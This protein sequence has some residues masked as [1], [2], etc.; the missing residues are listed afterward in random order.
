MRHRGISSALRFGTLSV[1]AQSA[2]KKVSVSIEVRDFRQTIGFDLVLFFLLLGWQRPNKKGST[3]G[4]QRGQRSVEG[5]YR[6]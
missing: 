3:E 1:F 5:A 2:L 4:S 6:G